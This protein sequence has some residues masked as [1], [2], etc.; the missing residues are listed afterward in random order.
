MAYR[1]EQ[2]FA[3]A[4]P[5]EHTTRTVHNYTTLRCF[6][7][8]GLIALI[9]IARPMRSWYGKNADVHERMYVAYNVAMWS[10][11]IQCPGTRC[12]EDRNIMFMLDTNA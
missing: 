12:S 3:H 7:G 9:L 8:D 5:I 10:K 2:P 1:E 4:S 6:S 11:P